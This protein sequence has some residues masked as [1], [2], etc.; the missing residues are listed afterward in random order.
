MQGRGWGAPQSGLFWTFPQDAAKTNHSGT[1]HNGLFRFP[2]TG[3]RNEYRQFWMLTVA[4]TVITPS[5]S[6]VTMANL[7]DN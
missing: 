4:R 7:T 2:S 1:S 5:Y 3:L 6:L